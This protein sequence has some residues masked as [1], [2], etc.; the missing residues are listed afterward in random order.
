MLRKGDHFLNNLNITKK[1]KLNTEPNENYRDLNKENLC[2]KSLFEDLND[3]SGNEQLN[4]QKG[5]EQSGYGSTMISPTFQSPDLV[6]LKDDRFRQD[7]SYL[8]INFSLKDMDK[9]SKD[10]Q[11]NNSVKQADNAFKAN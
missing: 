4:K 3:S 9:A 6:N 11:K 10:T 2:S 5:H 1:N 8:N 7:K